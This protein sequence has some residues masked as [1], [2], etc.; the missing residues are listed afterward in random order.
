MRP[1]YTGPVSYPAHR[2]P[3]LLHCNERENIDEIYRENIR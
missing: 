1:V 2:L 3:S